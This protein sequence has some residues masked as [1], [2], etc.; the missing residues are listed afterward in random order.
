MAAAQSRT[1]LI[2]HLTAVEEI[3][4][5]LDRTALE[6]LTD[7]ANYT[8]LAAEMVDRM[9]AGARRPVMRSRHGPRGRDDAP[10]VDPDAGWPSRCPCRLPC[11]APARAHCARARTVELIV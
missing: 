5:H 3:T 10:S 8:G 11:G 9:H 6:R 7:P 4:A 1:P 2:D